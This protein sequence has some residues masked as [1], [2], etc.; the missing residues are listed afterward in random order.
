[1]LVNRN[2]RTDSAVRLD[3]PVRGITGGRFLNI[4]FFAVHG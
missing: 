4:V 3:I 2:S 1:M